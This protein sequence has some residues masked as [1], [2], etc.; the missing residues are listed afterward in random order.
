MG[1]VAGLSGPTDLGCGA[2]A[3]RMGRRCWSPRA[4]GLRAFTARMPEIENQF[5]FV[6][7]VRLPVKVSQMTSNGGPRNTQGGGDRVVLHAAATHRQDFALAPRKSSATS[8]RFNRPIRQRWESG[9]NSRLEFRPPSSVVTDPTIRA[10][11]VEHGTKSRAEPD[12]RRGR[13]GV[14]S[15]RSRH[16]GSPLF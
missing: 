6:G 14:L 12:R 1:Y 2:N 10:N 3:P 7:G 4:G 13:V 15:F 16:E 11:S 9:L 8:Q 5:R